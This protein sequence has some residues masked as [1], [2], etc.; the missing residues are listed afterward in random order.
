MTGGR[1]VVHGGDLTYSISAPID[2]RLFSGSIY[3]NYENISRAFIIGL[4]SIGLPIEVQRKTLSGRELKKPSCFGA[5]SFSEITV[6][7]KKVIGSA[8]K[9]WHDA[10]MQQGSIMMD[11]NRQELCEIFNI[12]K[13]S[14]I[15]GL[16]EFMPSLSIEALK[17][18]IIDGFNEAFGVEM[19]RGE[20]TEDELN[21]AVEL[22]DK[23]YSLHT[24]NYRR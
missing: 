15:G 24:W 18:A 16:R 13:H 7:G 11:I 5:V 10:I 14:G 8:Q 1:A 23:K 2:K 12:E 4:R 20:P 22:R 3:R 17:R 6:H 19:V 9:K 21:M